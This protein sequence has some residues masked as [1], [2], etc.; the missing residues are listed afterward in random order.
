V[1]PD[2]L[3]VGAGCAGLSLAVHLLETRRA[4]LRVA[5]LDPRTAFGRDRTWCF[6]KT[7][8][9]PF[10]RCV[11]RGWTRWRVASGGREV[12]RGSARLP[13]QHLPADAFYE[14]AIRRIRASGGMSL[15]LGASVHA[16]ADHGDRVVAETDLGRIRARVV[17]DGRAAPRTALAPGELGFLQ[18][19]VGW[20]VH[21][22]A[23]VFDAPVATL[24]D[25]RVDQEDGIH[26]VYVLPFSAT[27]ALVEDT[28]FSARALPDERHA[29]AI[30]GY[31]DRI[32]ARRWRVAH[33]ERGVLPMIAGPV[34]PRPSPRVYRIGL[35][36]GLAKPSTGFAFLSI[37][38]FSRALA[39]RLGE[40]ELPAP[41]A[42]RPPRTALLDRIFLSYLARR[43]DR[44]PDLFARL[45]E[46]APA[47]ALVRFLSESG[48]VADDLRVMAALPAFPF[49]RE[50]IRALWSAA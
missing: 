48:T 44:A 18:H 37:Q 9:H 28:V 42:V 4:G 14:H 23:P 16:I 11:D 7:M 43:P 36:G 35:A 40:E 5:I 29:A 34:P 49:T 8:D 50:A 20:L 41:P 25:F 30:S 13:Y 3:I 33:R 17:F 12:I 6:W 1:E 24:M 10:E 47:E 21:A 46:R 27:E 15:H 32:G 45:F 26:F 39:A 19:F 2:Y 31:L 38:R 22:D